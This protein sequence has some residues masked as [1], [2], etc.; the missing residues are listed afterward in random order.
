MKHWTEDDLID[1]IYGI[2]PS[3]GHLD[4][5]PECRARR[6]VIA[7]RRAEHRKLPDLP[8]SFLAAQQRA[9]Y[10]RAEQCVSRSPWARAAVAC[11]GVTV[12][13][14]GLVVSR[15]RDTAAADAQMLAEA[16]AAAAADMPRAA[17][18]INALF[19]EAP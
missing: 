14:V 8:A 9:V 19:E 1:S 7:Q 10:A 4:T 12:L 6:D 16:Y 13:A 3:D 15:P 17:E 5:C 11:A 2:G 18:P